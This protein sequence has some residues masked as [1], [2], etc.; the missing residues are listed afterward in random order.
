MWVRARLCFSVGCLVFLV[1]ACAK[2]PEG[3]KPTQ[4][5]IAPEVL[6]DDTSIP[7]EWGPL[8]SVSSSGIYKPWLQLWFQDEEGTIRMVPYNVQGHRFSPNVRR[9]PRK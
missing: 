7:K 4:T 8:V 1:L 6:P 9:I 2:L 5:A 3:T